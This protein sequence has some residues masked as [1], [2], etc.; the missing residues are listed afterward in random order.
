MVV[1]A[2]LGVAACGGDEKKGGDG[3][4]KEGGE[5]TIAQ[6]S[7]PD[8]LD[9][10]SAYT[11][12]A[13]EPLWQV[14]TP[15][16]TYA[17]ADGEAGAKL[18]PGLAEK[19]PEASPDGKSYSFKLREGLKYS[20]GTEVK[21]SDFEHTVKRV[22]T[23]ESGGSGFFLGIEGAEEYAEAGKEKA[24]IGGIE[25]DDAT[26]E[27]TIDL[28]EPDGTFLNVLATNFAGMVPGDTSFKVL[29]KEPPPGVGPYKITESVPN[30]QFVLEKN[31]NFNVPRIPPGKIDKI[32]TKIIKSQPRQTQDVIANKLDYSFD[33]PPADL[34][35]DVRSRNKDRYKEFPVVD[36]R[37]FWFNTR[38]KPF[39]KKEVRQAVSFAVDERAISR[40]YGG[41]LQPACNFLPPGMPGYQK[42][43]PCPYGDPNGEPDIAKAKQM[44]EAAGETGTEV[45]VYGNTDDPTPKTTEYFADVMNEIGL[46]ATP[47]ILDAGVYFQAIGNEKTKAQTGY[48]GWFQ[49]FPHPANFFQLV[50]GTSIQP[51][52]S[53][54]Y[55]NID[56][57]QITSGYEKLK[58]ETDLASVAGQ[59]AELDRRLV[60]E[61][62]LVPYGNAK[63]ALHVS[64]RVD[65]DSVKIHPLYKVDYS[66]FALK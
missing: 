41:R 12:N 17:R 33:P 14:Y 1:A 44:I 47:K 22:L 15:P 39:D 61:A 65:F 53:I 8:F 3:A 40:I 11:V 59:W 42:I 63:E 64:E 16:V 38:E 35:A 20:N 32:T 10:A 55:G 62:Y 54:N 2:T 27:V 51:T 45:T 37:Y 18:I 49:D 46:K 19:L 25:T 34:I 43:D 5:L 26:G 28:K 31:A 66:S 30:R 60:E 4:A 9:P 24:D 58:Q 13:W 36:V 29:T 56:D 7:Q 52:N 57:P 48:A 23:Q 6:P 50:S 21:A